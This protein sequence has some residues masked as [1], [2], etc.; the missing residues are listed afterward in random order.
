M[1]SARRHCDCELISFEGQWRLV[2]TNIRYP[3]TP[4]VLREYVPPTC[5]TTSIRTHGI[6]ARASQDST[7]TL[8]EPM[9][10]SDGSMT[11]SVFVPRGTNVLLGVRAC[12]RDKRLWGDDAEEWKPE[13]WLAPLP[14]SVADAHMPGILSLRRILRSPVADPISQV[15]TAI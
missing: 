2:D 10:S 1:P 5:I 4:I 7:L 13:R 9:R 11:D 14:Q 6:F 15:Y 12:N 8:S 3:P